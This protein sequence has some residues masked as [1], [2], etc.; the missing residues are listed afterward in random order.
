MCRIDRGCFQVS[1]KHFRAQL[2]AW[3]DRLAALRNIPPVL[4][5]VWESGPAV[6][7]AGMVLRLI[8]ALV[9]VAMLYVSKL[10]IDL[11]VATVKTPGT[12]ADG[13]WLLLA[14]EFVLAAAGNV[15]GRGIDYFDGRLADQFSREVSLRI[16]D[17]AAKLD[18]ASFEDP[19]FYDKLERAR[20]QATDRIGMLTAIGRLIQQT[21]TLV[22]L[23]A[24]VIWFRRYCLPSW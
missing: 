4:K 17:H 2:N 21:I 14:M 10:I 9:P 24:G 7:A 15:L 16:M 13:I 8:V 18:L 23:S 1:G 22:S 3:R 6:T 11:V 5:L 12:P 20:V 19:A